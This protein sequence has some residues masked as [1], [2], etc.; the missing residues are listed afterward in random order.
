MLRSGSQKLY[1]TSA[2]SMAVRNFFGAAP[3]PP[4]SFEKFPPAPRPEGV[5]DTW[6]ASHIDTD[7]GYFEDDVFPVALPGETLEEYCRRVP[8]IWSPCSRA[9]D[10]VDVRAMHTIEFAADIQL[11][12]HQ[13]SERPLLKIP[14]LDSDWHEAQE[15]EMKL[16]NPPDPFTILGVIPPEIDPEEAEAACKI[17]MEGAARVG[18]GHWFESD[19]FAD[20]W[21]ELTGLQVEEMPFEKS[22][23]R[24]LELNPGLTLEGFA[25]KMVPGINTDPYFV[26]ARNEC[27][28]RIVEREGG[29]QNGET[30][31]A[32]I[33]R[34]I[35]RESNEETQT[36]VRKMEF[37]HVDE[38]GNVLS[39][40]K[41]FKGPSTGAKITE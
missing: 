29:P 39:S 35:E 4:A 22:L 36:T 19:N 21:V 3:T 24:L 38:D 28:K 23:D 33:K 13:F 31:E 10:V 8:N 37:R 7:L 27:A 6:S 40:V 16:E 30:M 17:I 41:N 18:Y 20:F 25:E 12:D 1:R 9:T 32:A 2:Y 11:E 5:P 26:E 15:Q 14:P 34:I